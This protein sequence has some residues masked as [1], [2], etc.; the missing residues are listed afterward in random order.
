VHIATKR[1]QAG[2][3]LQRLIKL[4]EDDRVSLG[5]RPS[6]TRVAG[7]LQTEARD[8]PDVR[9]DET[10]VRP[11]HEPSTSLEYYVFYAWDDDTEG[12]KERERTVDRLCAEA[13]ARGL[14]IIRDKSAMKIGDRI[15][16]FLD[17]IGKGAVDGRVCIALSD[18]TSSPP[19]ACTNY[20]T[21]GASLLPG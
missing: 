21:C 19:T 16:K 5:A 4:V 13:E 8:G 14:A 7:V 9:A 1:G 12:G 2:L 11:A 3:L 6:G 20:S 10:L 18:K 15:S 17:R